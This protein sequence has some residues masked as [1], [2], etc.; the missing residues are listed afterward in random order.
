MVSDSSAVSSKSVMRCPRC[1]WV[2]VT[3][4]T[5]TVLYIGLSMEPMGDHFVCTNPVCKVERI[6]GE[7]GVVLVKGLQKEEA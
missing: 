5:D 3:K 7:N 6:Y 1:Q 4:V 2:S